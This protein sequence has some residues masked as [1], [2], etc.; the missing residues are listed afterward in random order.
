MASQSPARVAERIHDH[1]GLVDLGGH[2]GGGVAVAASGSGAGVERGRII[3]SPDVGPEVVLVVGAP[4]C[5]DGGGRRRRGRT[6]RARV[7][8]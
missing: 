6:E 5:G 3:T 2:R 8:S 4:G 7:R 1:V